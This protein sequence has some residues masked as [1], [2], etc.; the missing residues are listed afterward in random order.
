MVLDKDRLLAVQGESVTLLLRRRLNGFKVRDAI[1][2]KRR[3][4][5][6]RPPESGWMSLERLLPEGISVVL[7][8]FVGCGVCIVEVKAKTT[9]EARRSG[10]NVHHVRTYL[11]QV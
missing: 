7:M 6:R 8:V 1:E 10:P 9:A 4:D 2:L 11:Q 3:R 5:P